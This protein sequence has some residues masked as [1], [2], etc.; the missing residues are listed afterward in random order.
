L[1]PE[2]KVLTHGFET[3][4]TPLYKFHLQYKLR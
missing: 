4:P 1:A 2:G 3:N